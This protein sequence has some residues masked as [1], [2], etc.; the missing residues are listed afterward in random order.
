MNLDSCSFILIF[1]LST[2]LLQL[3]ESASLSAQQEID[4]D[5]LPVSTRTSSNPTL[6][7]IVSL[8]VFQNVEGAIA[9]WPFGKSIPAPEVFT[10]G[11]QP[12]IQL[13]D[14]YGSVQT[15]FCP[16]VG[17]CQHISYSV[18]AN[19]YNN[20]GCAILGGTPVVN[21]VQG[22]AKFTDLF[23]DIPQSNYTLQ[24]SAGSTSTSPIG[25][26]PLQVISDPFDVALGFINLHWNIPTQIPVA[27]A[28]LSII[29]M[30]VNHYD[31]LIQSWMP[32]T[33]YDDDIQVSLNLPGC[34][35][36]GGPELI[37]R[38][39][40]FGNPPNIINGNR[41]SVPCQN[42]NA[43]VTDLQVILSGTYRLT[44]ESNGM[45]CQS[46]TFSIAPSN[47]AVVYVLQQPSSVVT[48][49]VMFSQMPI[50]DVVDK[51]NNTVSGKGF[52]VNAQVYLVSGQSTSLWSCLDTACDY[53]VPFKDQTVESTSG[54][55]TFQNIM[56]K[57]AGN[58]IRISF[59]VTNILNSAI[60]IDP[61][62]SAPV[63]VLP[64]V[65]IG[66]KVAM[67]PRTQLWKDVDVVPLGATA[68]I[69]FAQQPLVSLF[70]FSIR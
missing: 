32:V 14:M 36:L 31:R 67:S 7:G 26:A 53:S 69:P 3:T 41:F 2:F 48:S 51:Y 64:G 70:P 39:L 25:W 56:I 44:F 9:N 37:C 63:N 50:I 30:Q 29:Y 66:M 34:Q 18:T 8:K 13:L 20:P 22:V 42:G 16:L 12:T 24:F 27:G 35:N 52:V 45:R 23:I 54:V 60:S 5:I 28:N 59:I 19:I 55:Y 61:V 58:G 68:G 10:Q 21:S 47:A 1:S 49:G 38:N 43:S 4:T 15:E 65:Y 33:T 40:A 62:F 57:A 6:T 46:L 11:S 17:P